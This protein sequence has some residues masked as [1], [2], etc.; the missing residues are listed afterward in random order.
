[1][2]IEGTE[3][4]FEKKVD[5]IIEMFP[6]FSYHVIALR[7]E[8]NQENE[9][10]TIESL[11][12]S[13]PPTTSSSRKVS[14]SNQWTDVNATTMA[15]KLKFDSV[16]DKFK[17]IED[18]ILESIYYFHDCSLDKTVET[19]KQLYPL[20]DST[21][22]LISKE[23]YKQ[24]EHEETSDKI[25][26][27]KEEEEEKRSKLIAKEELRRKQQ[28]KFHV[29]QKKK[30]KSKNK[31]EYEPFDLSEKAVMTARVR[32]TY[33]R[34][35][36][37]AYLNGDTIRAN[38]LSRMGRQ[39]H[40]QVQEFQ[41]KMK[42]ELLERTVQRE[43]KVTTLDLHGLFVKEALDT[44]MDL[45]NNLKKKKTNGSQLL[46]VI[47]GAGK[48][49]SGGKA[50]IKPAVLSFLRDNGFS[51]KEVNSGVLLVLVKNDL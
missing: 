47:T 33:F 21:L 42:E 35:A 14:T 30:T 25:A 23:K 2:C 45:I 1:M 12:R 27:V 39:Y 3:D 17:G 28:E 50:R 6:T 10:Q 19:I 36:T 44:M 48:H 37:L 8:E 22:Q 51:Y 15:S 9:E 29:V 31:G 11:I 7:L 18:S 46:E 43:E 41:S 20:Y 40:S 38:E 13:P 32:D 5:K 24:V 4:L 16:K 34:Q 26:S 49:S